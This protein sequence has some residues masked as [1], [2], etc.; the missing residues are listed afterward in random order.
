MNID[1]QFQIEV[2]PFVVVTGNSKVYVIINN[3]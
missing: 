2:E 1:A 3:Y